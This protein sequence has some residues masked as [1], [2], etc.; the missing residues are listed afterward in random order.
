MKLTPTKYFIF[1]GGEVHCKLSNDE[2]INTIVCLDYTMNG[3][4]ALCEIKEILD[5]KGLTSNLIYPYFPYA[6]QDRVINEDEPFSLKVFCSL[7]NSQ[8]FNS[9]TIW[10]P[11]SDVAGA[12]INKV[13]IVPQWEIAKSNIPEIFF[14]DT[15]YLWVAPDAGAYKK[16]SKLMPQDKRIII[17]TKERN[18]LGEI[19]RT[20]VYSS[21][22]LHGKNC[23]VVDDICDGG[24]TFIE[25]GKALKE[26]GA[27]K[28][29]LYVTHGIFSKG[30]SE[31]MKYY[32]AI[33]TTSSFNVYNHKN[34]TIGNIL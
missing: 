28:L 2:E 4:M 10:D 17:G 25:L 18:A 7:L 30:L 11:H 23:V 13:N 12:L 5:R 32:E 15:Q 24:R 27:C 14:N 19:V 6:R 9:V 31:L 8:K 1:S 26:K 33:Y 3:F 20:N 29:Y 16:L 21:V 22:D 34:L